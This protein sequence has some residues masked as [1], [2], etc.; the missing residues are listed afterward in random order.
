[1]N[2]IIKHNGE[3]LTNY[4]TGTQGTWDIIATESGT[5]GV[6]TCT[7]TFKSRNTGELMPVSREK[8]YKWAESGAITLDT[9]KKKPNGKRT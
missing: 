1:M 6:M 2:Q 3:Y 4:F 8:I 5:G 9:V 7:D